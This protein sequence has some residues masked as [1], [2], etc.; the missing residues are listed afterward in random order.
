M[1]VHKDFKRLVRE[2]AQRT[3]ESYAA[4]RRSLLAKA[5]QGSP[6]PIVRELWFTRATKGYSGKPAKPTGFEHHRITVTASGALHVEAE[7]A[8]RNYGDHR[9]TLVAHE[10][11]CRSRFEYAS[12]P[13]VVDAQWRDGA[14]TGNAAVGDDD[15][16]EFALP[17]V[18]VDDAKPIPSVVG[19]FLPLRLARE[20]GELASYTP[21]PEDA[22]PA[23]RPAQ[24]KS[25]FPVMG[26]S[27]RPLTVR[28]VVV[29]R[30]EETIAMGGRRKVAA[31]RYDH[32]A[33]DGTVLETTWIGE[34]DT[35]VRYEQL[36]CVL[37]AT[38]PDQANGQPA[39]SVD[40]DRPR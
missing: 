15:A 34:D 20:G 14:W 38:A 4:A 28:R 5:P 37:V 23:W 2:R 16:Q 11:R 19:R 32:V 31:F 35:V 36:G 30:G 12:P 9:Y 13:I 25:W 29:G 33:T 27:R 6:P 39:G 21:V 17:A 24:P 10:H 3:G 18:V 8:F 40:G 26:A 7:V 1:T 22:F